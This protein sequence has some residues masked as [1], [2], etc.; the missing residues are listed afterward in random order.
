MGSFKQQKDDDKLYALLRPGR[1]TYLKIA[2]ILGNPS[3]SSVILIIEKMSQ[4]IATRT[5]LFRYLKANDYE[6]IYVTLNTPI[7]NLVDTLEKASINIENTY[8]IDGVTKTTESEAIESEHCRYLES[9]R[10]VV[11]LSILIDELLS[12]IQHPKK[13]VVIDSISTLMVYNSEQAIKQFAHSITGKIK[14]KNASGIIIASDDT[15]NEA[16][17]SIAHFCDKT[18]KLSD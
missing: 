11:D 4:H 8:F 13:V 14:S 5:E 18:L 9:P 10:D 1:N 15:D 7:A 12:K 6:G 2:E 17:N 3:Q 16:L